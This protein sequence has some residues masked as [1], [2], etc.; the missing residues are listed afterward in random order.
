VSEVHNLWNKENEVNRQEI[1][2]SSDGLQLKNYVTS[3]DFSC[4]ETVWNPIG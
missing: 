3:S 2:I 4:V 1:G